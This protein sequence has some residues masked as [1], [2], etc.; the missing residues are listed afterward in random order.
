MYSKS[1]ITVA[2]V[3]LWLALAAG[4]RGAQP[5]KVFEQ[6]FGRAYNKALKSGKL[7]DDLEISRQIIEAVGD[8]DKAEAPFQKYC[9]IQLLTMLT[10]NTNEGLVEADRALG[11]LY[12][13]DPA[14]GKS[15][16]DKVLLV[17]RTAY[18]AAAKNRRVQAGRL[19]MELL[20]NAA[21][22]CVDRGEYAKADQY[23][24]DALIVSRQIRVDHPSLTQLQNQLSRRADDK[25]RADQLGKQFETQTSDKALGKRL[26]DLYLYRLSDFI[27][28]AAV[29]AQ[30]GD[31]ATTEMITTSNARSHTLSEKQL[32]EL[33]Q[34]YEG[35]AEK[36][37]P[38]YSGRMLDR[39]RDYLLR[40]MA[41][42]PVRD[43]AYV[44][45]KLKLVGVEDKLLALKGSEGEPAKGTASGSDRSTASSGSTKPG[46]DKKPATAL[47]DRDDGETFDLVKGLKITRDVQSG[48]WASRSGQLAN[49]DDAGTSSVTL[50]YEVKGD[51]KLTLICKMIK[52]EAYSQHM[53]VYFPFDDRVLGFKI[54]GRQSTYYS[55]SYRPVL[56]MNNSPS[57]SGDY[58]LRLGMT[59]KIEI[60]VREIGSKRRQV[61]VEYNGKPCLLWQGAT[62][63]I[64]AES[65]HTRGKPSQRVSITLHDAQVSFSDIK[66]K[67]IK[68]TCKATE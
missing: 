14:A 36:A 16:Q 65:Y 2:T 26:R 30:I 52:T 45:A 58:R 22:R 15:W 37:S 66:L 39:S 7:Q 24:R 1:I 38:L 60:T 63:Q 23:C 43:I 49:L 10:R 4:A 44:R 6:L 42:H 28:A 46:S 9:M 3:S 35:L 12:R 50:P 27:S 5:E 56:L 8:V 21:N 48:R 57:S 25:D 53:N 55:D 40:Y 11:P 67:M 32:L 64:S 62:K 29:A 19:Y 31:Q 17:A 47:F 54:Y 18:T 33:A 13:A 51:Y 41:V 20:Y 59:C 61:K 68:G 34:W